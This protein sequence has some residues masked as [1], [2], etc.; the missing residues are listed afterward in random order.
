MPIELLEDPTAL[1]PERVIVFE[2]GGTV[3][4]FLRAL[5]KIEGLEFMTELESE[6]EPSEDFAVTKDGQDVVGKESLN[7]AKRDHTILSPAEALNVLTLGARHHDN[8]QNRPATF[9]VMIP[10]AAIRSP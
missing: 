7:D 4:D 5:G 1:A 3:P 8:V 6:F 9:N 10:S 2:I